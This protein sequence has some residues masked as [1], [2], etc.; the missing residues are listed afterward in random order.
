M[1]PV[2]KTTILFCLK[3]S[4]LILAIASLTLVVHAQVPG[5]NINMVS[6]TQWPGG[7]PFLQRQNEPSIAVSSRNPQHLLAGA[8][9]YRTVDLPYPDV[10]SDDNTACPP[11]QKCAEP[12]LGVFKSGDGGETWQS[13]LL[14]GYPQD[15]S[16]EGRG[17]PLKRFTTAS[18]PVV[19]AGTNGLF[20]F[21]GI[22]FNRGTNNGVVFVAR[23][24]DL[25]NKENGDVTQ[26]RD[27][28]RYVDTIAVASG[29]ATQFLD[30]PVVAV[31]V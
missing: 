16:P 18:D 17:S 10:S 20:Y 13:I 1:P 19:R 3:P 14:P 27:S 26:G 6:G 11:N 24:M 28:L 8:N 15:V 12:W 22:A 4:A 30:K 23:F 21:N 2:K 25:N 9:D 5:R 7:D 29:T 31:D